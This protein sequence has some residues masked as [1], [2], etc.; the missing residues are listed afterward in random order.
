M[1][2]LAFTWFVLMV[3]S[4]AAAAP[5]STPTLAVCKADW[6]TWSGSKTETLTLDQIS[7]RMNEMVACANEAHRR[8]HSDK[9]TLAYLDEFYRTHTELANRCFDFIARHGLRGQFDD[10]DAAGQR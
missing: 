4:G 8:H 2:T 6:T 7:I 10:E 1:R 9:K 3:A 5:D